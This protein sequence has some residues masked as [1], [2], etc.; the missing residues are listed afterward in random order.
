MGH[1]PKQITELTS[2]EVAY[3]KPAAQAMGLIE[4][5]ICR[6]EKKIQPACEL[7]VFVVRFI[8]SLE[9][10]SPKRWWVQENGND[11]AFDREDAAVAYV[12]GLKD[13][14]IVLCE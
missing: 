12:R 10:R 5:G 4:R 8:D 6:L 14:R 11:I 1:L 7:P 9:D 13:P 2:T 3:E